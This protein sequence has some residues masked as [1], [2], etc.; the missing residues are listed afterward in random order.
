MILPRSLGNERPGYR[1][2]IASRCIV[3]LFSG[4]NPRLNLPLPREG[5]YKADHSPAFY[6]PYCARFAESVILEN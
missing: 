3:E 2:Q 5:V 4:V 1:N 6:A